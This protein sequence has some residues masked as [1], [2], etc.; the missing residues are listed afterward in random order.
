MVGGPSRAVPES[1]TESRLR[2][3]TSGLL[4]SQA[5]KTPLR[6]GAKHAT[7]PTE[8]TKPSSFDCDRATRIDL[9]QCVYTVAGRHFVP[10]GA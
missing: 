3:L 9:I 2:E 8:G 7:L 10:G 5:A 4:S 1:R 6:S